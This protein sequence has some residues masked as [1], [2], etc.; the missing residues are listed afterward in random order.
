[1]GKV[2]AIEHLTLDGV[3]QGPGKPDEDRRGNFQYGGWG[4]ANSDPAM[5]RAMGARMGT[6]WSLLV[7]RVTYE[8][9]YRAWAR[10]AQ[11]NPFSDALNNI[12]KLVASTTLH[13]PLAWRNSTLLTGDVLDAVAERKR[14]SGNALI[15]FG[16]GVLVQSLMARQLVD[17]FLLFIHP[18]V[19]GTGLKLFPDG[20]TH[21]RLRCTESSTTPGGVIIAAFAPSPER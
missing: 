21:T 4:A 2:V 1:M 6:G 7:G 18:V 20:V 16:S 8:D 10:P 11:P 17:E 9:L 3:M 15:I 5:Q 14:A 19:L 13:E 12:E